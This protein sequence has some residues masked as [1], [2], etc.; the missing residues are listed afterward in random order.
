[1]R[2]DAQAGSKSFV[3]VCQCTVETFYGLKPVSNFV[4]FRRTGT[5]S[6]RISCDDL[7]ARPAGVPPSR[8]HGLI[9][10]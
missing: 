4:F 6:A 7:A 9:G 1:M 5:A 10:R 3:L 2:A 8:M